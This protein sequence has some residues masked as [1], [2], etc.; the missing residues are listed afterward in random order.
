MT[1]LSIKVGSFSGIEIRLHYSWFIIF[2]LLTYSL[3]TGYLPTGY[4]GQSNSFYWGKGAISAALLFISVL[5]HEFGHSLVAIY[6][7][8]PVKR[9][10]LYFLGGV[11]E[12]EEEAHT[13]GA[14][15]R[16]AVVGP[17]ISIALGIIFYGLQIIPSLPLGAIAVFY[18]SSYINF[19]LGA[20]NLIPAFPM[21]G[22]RVF[23]ALIWTRKD[24]LYS[25][26]LAVQVSKLLSLGFMTY[27]FFTI[28]SSTIFDGFWI[29]LIGF[30]IYNSAEESMAEAKVSQ[31]LTGVTIAEIMTRDVHT[32]EPN[33]S[34]QQLVDYQMSKYKHHG[35]PVTIGEKLI[36]I[37]TEEDIRRVEPELWD[38]KRVEDIMVPIDKLVTIKPG[39]AAMDAFIKMAKANVGRLPV[40]DGEKLVGIITRSDLLRAVQRRLSIRS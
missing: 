4:P 36:G 37:V 33:L 2:V 20:F 9:I 26:K 38:E 35:F 19:V 18:Y 32:V 28:I 7:K 13:P 27:G 23:R 22:G 17:L 24:Y 10:T 12:I 16:L 21:D 30:Y 39:D 15:F 11:S 40:V 8:V 14:E 34:I 29:L 3:A 6:Y 1:I 31:A 5:L 25:T